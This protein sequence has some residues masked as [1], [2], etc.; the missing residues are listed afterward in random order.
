MQFSS[1][2]FSGLRSLF[3]VSFFSCLSLLVLSACGGAGGTSSPDMDGGASSAEPKYDAQIRYTRFGIPHIKAEDWGSLGYGVGY[4]FA[5]DNICTLAEDILTIDGERSKYFGPDG[6]HGIIGAF[7]ANN[8]ESDFAFKFLITEE[9]TDQFLA[10]QSPLALEVGEGYVAGYNRYVREL[11]AGQYPGRH[12]ACVNEP[13]L[14]ELTIRDLI[15]RYIRLA[16]LASSTVF[17]D[18]IANAAP[19][20]NTALHPNNVKRPIEYAEAQHAHGESKD[21]VHDNYVSLRHVEDMPIGSN[22]YG[23]G[24]QGTTDGSTLL[25]GNPHFPWYG[26]ERL[27]AFHITIPGVVNSMGS[28]LHGVPV[29]LIAFNENFAWSHTVSAAYR[30]TVYELTLGSTPTSYIFDNQEVQMEP[31]EITIEVKN[32]DG[33]MG[34]ETRTLYNTRYGPVTIVADNV[35]D[36]GSNKAYAIRDANYENVQLIEQ[37]LQWNQ[38]DDLE[39][40]IALQKSILGVPWVNTVAV[41]ANQDAYYGDVTV[42]PNVPDDMLTPAPSGCAAEPV[43][44]TVQQLVPGL[45]VLDGSRSACDWRNDADAPQE[46]IFGASNLPTLR[47]DDWLHNCNDSYWLSNPD[48]PITGFATIIGDEDTARSLRTR[49]CMIQVQQRLAGNGDDGLP[50]SNFTLEQFQD[51]A[52][53]SRVYTAELARDA[54]VND[55][56]GSAVGGMLPGSNGSVDVSNAC[57]VLADWDMTTN[58]DS[59]GAHIWREFWHLANDSSALW[60]TPYDSNDPVNTP[61]DLNTN[62]VTGVEIYRALADAVQT[63]QDAGVAMDARF[64]TL[65]RDVKNGTDIEMYGGPGA[66]GNFTIAIPYSERPHDMS[67]SG[68]LPIQA[69]GYPLITYGNSWVYTVQYPAS[70]RVQANGYVTYSQSTDP[71]S[72]HYADYTEAYANKEWPLLPFHEDEIQAQL[73][74]QLQISE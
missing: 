33:S 11:Q 37:F 13:W 12:A 18:G 73:V 47:R 71:A 20:V 53:G 32:A 61:R 58:V 74:R 48:E 49:L 16:M 10:A 42:V 43:H 25:L 56:C 38:A 3:S 35:L 29:P 39:D 4:A 9:K 28:G 5:T 15:R 65:Q 55:I 40:F 21:I 59:V 45:P 66:T 27:H 67:Q 6:E 34:T 8:N 30:F 26:T 19:P 44:S 22:M 1:L 52:L 41:G 50:G 69:D 64:G 70:G 31:V 7:F 23:I 36:W 60:N 54:V 57:D 46:G 14:R 24:P 51:V 62:P 17:R 63:I 2:C 68:R 72:P